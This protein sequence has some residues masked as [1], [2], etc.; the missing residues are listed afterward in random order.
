MEAAELSSS[1]IYTEPLK[2]PIKKI[3][4]SAEIAKLIPP[5]QGGTFFAETAEREMV[6]VERNT[7]NYYVKIIK[8]RGER[9]FFDCTEYD[10][11][12]NILC[13]FFED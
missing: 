9:V 10:N 12:G 2:L 5:E 6:L 4:S 1:K 11:N 3:N 8:K 13:V 7:D